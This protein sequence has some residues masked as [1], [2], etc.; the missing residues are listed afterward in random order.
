MNQNNKQYLYDKNYN[1]CQTKGTNAINQPYLDQR[2]KSP[3]NA[4]LLHSTNPEAN[5]KAGP[6]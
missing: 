3:A 5:E 2:K 4:N 6:P 1:I